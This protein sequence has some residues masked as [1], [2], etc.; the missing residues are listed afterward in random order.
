MIS[1]ALLVTRCVFVFV[2]TNTGPTPFH[3]TV[4]CCRRAKATK[5]LEEL[6]GGPRLVVD[7][8]LHLL[9][10]P[11][12]ALLRTLSSSIRYAVDSSRAAKRLSWGVGDPE[13]VP[14]ALTPSN[15]T[16]DGTL[17]VVEMRAVGGRQVLVYSALSRSLFSNLGFFP[18]PAYSCHAGLRLNKRRL[19]IFTTRLYEDILITYDLTNP[20]SPECKT[21]RSPGRLPLLCA[22]VDREHEMTVYNFSPTVV[23]TNNVATGR[24]EGRLNTGEEVSSV[25]LGW[26]RG[27][28]LVRGKSSPTLLCLHL[29][30]S[31]ILCRADLASLM[32]PSFKHNIHMSRDCIVVTKETEKGIQVAVWVYREVQRKKEGNG[33]DKEGIL[34]NKPSYKEME[35]AGEETP[36]RVVLTNL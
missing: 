5:M 3:L 30:T 11:E 25:L 23:C 14:L 36:L 18:H 17:V 1:F 34:L 31:E 28:V 8:L 4:H 24:L 7:A 22:D 19:T 26:P 13:N 12:L 35:W 27:L 2:S 33:P 32:L 10:L 20:R 6:L 15:V 9:P 29:T 21:Q 16:R